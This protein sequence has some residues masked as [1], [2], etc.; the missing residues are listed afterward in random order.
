MS[1]SPPAAPPPSPRRV[2]KRWL[3][4]GLL[5]GLLALLLL[6]V[7]VR[8]TWADTVP[9]NPTTPEAGIVCQLLQTPDGAKQVRCAVVLD[10]PPPLVWRVV[11]DYDHF[12]ETFPTITSAE[13]RPEGDGLFHLNFVL[14]TPI[15]PMPVEAQIRHVETPERSTASWDQPSGDLLVNR[16]SWE[17]TPADAGR[18]LLVY[19]LE[20][21]VRHYP[22][23]LVR[24]ALL[25]R[26]PKIV[27][28]VRRRV[29]TLR[30]Q[31]R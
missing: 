5:L 16:G 27:D 11:T 13:A 7:Y 4:A 6:S 10:A 1:T 21:A 25:S 31:A 9:R 17:V 19:T 26:Q 23:F 15:G 29:T 8:G 2:R 14:Q 12:P 18:T 3:I 30:A 28:A 20:V 24:N 22:D